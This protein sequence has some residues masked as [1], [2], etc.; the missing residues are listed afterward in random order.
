MRR[1]MVGRAELWVAG[2]MLAGCAEG[3][4]PPAETPMVAITSDLEFTFG[5]RESEWC[6]SDSRAPLNPSCDDVGGSVPVLWPTV[7]VRLRP[8]EIDIHEVT[9]VQYR[10]C[11][12]M[13]VCDDGDDERH[14]ANGGP[15]QPKYYDNPQYEGHP[16]VRVSWQEA[17]TYCEWLGKRLPTEFEWERVARGPDSLARP[18]PAEGLEELDD[19]KTAGDQFATTY[20][21]PG[22]V[23]SGVVAS[24]RDYVDEPGAGRI[25]GL[26]GNA[27]EWTA[28]T[29]KVDITCQGEPPCSRDCETSD[30]QCA[31]EKRACPDCQADGAS[32]YYQCEGR[33]GQSIVCEPFAETEQPLPVAVLE[34]RSLL[35]NDIVVRGAG[36]S[37][38]DT[39][40]CQHF[41]GHRDRKFAGAISS[42]GDLGFRCVRDL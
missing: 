29:R 10:Y 31:Q 42:D 30:L 1:A 39:T 36:I 9:N 40:R 4:A 13:G 17:R 18:F 20:C 26:F 25:H 6:N 32:C 16:V 27:A 28:T 34:E 7:K 24:S 12:A 21:N 37:T 15:S 8:F 19:C 5:T 35:G 11:V 3:I 2:L 22:A 33:N 38:R 14:P 41:S 23:L